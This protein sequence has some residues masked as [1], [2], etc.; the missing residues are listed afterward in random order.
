MKQCCY[1]QSMLLCAVIQSDH[2]CRGFIALIP[3]VRT[4]AALHELRVNMIRFFSKVVAV[5]GPQAAYSH[6]NK[7]GCV[8]WAAALPRDVSTH[9]KRSY[10][11][12]ATAWVQSLGTAR[13]KA[14][15][16][17]WKSAVEAVAS[18]TSP[19]A[20]SN[21]G[22]SSKAPSALRLRGRARSVLLVLC[23]QVVCCAGACSFRELSAAACK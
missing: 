15:S 17:S 10:G 16:L 12:L 22:D 8:I 11:S 13:V 9:L 18:C 20:P 23:T 1:L 19:S 21:T 6:K 3:H 14:S 2:C 5:L 7:R 4:P